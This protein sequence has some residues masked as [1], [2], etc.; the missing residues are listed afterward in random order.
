M[1]GSNHLAE[2]DAAPLHLCRVCLR[3]LQ[4]AVGFDPLERARALAASCRAMGLEDEARW[5]D[6]RARFL[7]GT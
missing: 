1:N 6:D 3:K 2:T 7:E 4:H 5:W